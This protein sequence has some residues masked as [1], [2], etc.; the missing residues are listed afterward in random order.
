M[1]ITDQ[2][3]PECLRSTTDCT[4]STFFPF[5][6]WRVNSSG[7]ILLEAAFWITSGRIRGF[8]VHLPPPPARLPGTSGW[9]CPPSL[10]NI[11]RAETSH[12]RVKGLQAQ[13]TLLHTSGT[14]RWAVSRP[15]SLQE[16]SLWRR[17]LSVSGYHPS[18]I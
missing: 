15:Q 7:A 17:A 6:S 11:L 2:L 4:V 14:P 12:L 1:H 10:S 16:P 8:C 9:S 5:M 13:R 18:R 3:L